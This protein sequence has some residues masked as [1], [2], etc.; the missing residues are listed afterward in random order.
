MHTDNKNKGK[1]V[2]GEVLTEKLHGAT[3]GVEVK[4]LFNFPNSQESLV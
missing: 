3:I 2:L 1:L 4:Y